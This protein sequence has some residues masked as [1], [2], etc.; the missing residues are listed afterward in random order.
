MRTQTLAIDFI[1]E[2]A[3]HE[4]DVIEVSLAVIAQI[5]SATGETG[6]DDDIVHEGRATQVAVI[7]RAVDNL[8]CSRYCRHARRLLE[9][10]TVT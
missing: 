8:P 4:V 3:R 10:V 6:A 5:I 1:Q 9:P 7:G 2:R